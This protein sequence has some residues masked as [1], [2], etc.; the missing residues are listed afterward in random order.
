MYSLSEGYKYRIHGIWCFEPTCRKQRHKRF[1]GHLS[2][3]KTEEKTT[4]HMKEAQQTEEK[5]TQ[6]VI[7]EFFMKKIDKP[8]HNL[9]V[10]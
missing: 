1:A 6:K 4:F 7:Q 10:L 3:S 9:D 2:K 8:S 5:S